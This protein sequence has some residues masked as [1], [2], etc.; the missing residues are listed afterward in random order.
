MFRSA[1]MLEYGRAQNEH[2][3]CRMKSKG[4]SCSDRSGINDSHKLELHEK[5]QKLQLHDN[6][7]SALQKIIQIEPIKPEAC[8]VESGTNV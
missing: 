4:N 5:D 8:N 3:S 7:C 1:Y 6:S 2:D